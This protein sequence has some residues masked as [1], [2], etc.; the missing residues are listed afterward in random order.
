MTRILFSL[1]V[2][3]RVIRGCGDF[4]FRKWDGEI[5]TTGKKPGLSR[6]SLARKPFSLNR[7]VIVSDRGIGHAKGFSLGRSQMHLRAI[8]QPNQSHI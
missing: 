8:F 7:K 6:S 1:S 4:S 3:I 5:P 2:P